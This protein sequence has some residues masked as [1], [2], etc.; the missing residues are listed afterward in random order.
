M[1]QS[2]TLGAGLDWKTSLQELAATAALGAPEYRVDRG[3]PGPREGVRRAR[4]SSATRC[5]ARGTGRSKKEAEQKAAERPGPRST[6]RRRQ[7][8]LEP[9]VDATPTGADAR[10]RR[11]S[12]MPELPEV[13]VGPPRP[14]TTTSSG[15]RIAVGGVPGARVAPTAPARSRR[16]RRPARPGA[17]VGRPRGAASTSGWSLE[18]PDG[19]GRVC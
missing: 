15:A 3:R 9:K 14:R 6:E 4:R 5:S 2:A 19:H 8:G 18:A 11:A 10:S 16:P 1:T 17:V 12:G 13:E 7:P